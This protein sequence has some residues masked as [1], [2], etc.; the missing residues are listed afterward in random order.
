MLE[1]EN[2]WVAR[3]FFVNP[4]EPEELMHFRALTR[5][6]ACGALKRWV[7]TRYIDCEPIE[8]ITY[9]RVRSA[10]FGPLGERKPAVKTACYIAYHRPPEVDDDQPEPIGIDPEDTAKF[11]PKA[12]REFYG[13]R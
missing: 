6:D 1:T 13:P 9:Q 5:E 3:V 12:E 11:N 4:D 8:K 7:N 10:E 2:L